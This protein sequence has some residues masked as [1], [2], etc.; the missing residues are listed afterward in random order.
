MLVTELV[1]FVLL[2]LRRARMNFGQ[3]NNKAF[4]QIVQ[5]F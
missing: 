2:F 1:M 5:E 3:K 4:H